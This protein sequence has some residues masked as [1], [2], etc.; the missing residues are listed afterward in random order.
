M[1]RGPRHATFD[2]FA[3]LDMTEQ[4]TLLLSLFIL[5]SVSTWMI[6]HMGF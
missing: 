1:D 2:G 5:E 6:K 3:E 4:L